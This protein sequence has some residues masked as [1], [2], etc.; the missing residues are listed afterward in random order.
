MKRMTE[1]VIR[2][3]NNNCIDIVLTNEE[4]ENDKWI[5]RAIYI[6]PREGELFQYEGVRYHIDRIIH[7]YKEG[8]KPYIEFVVSEVQDNSVYELKG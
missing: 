3:I 4:W 7:H 6:M 1:T 8:F 5:T 2:R